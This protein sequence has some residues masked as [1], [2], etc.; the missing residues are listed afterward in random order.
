M[1]DNE[2]LHTILLSSQHIYHIFI[3]S[4]ITKLVIFYSH[5]STDVQVRFSVL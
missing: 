4:R 1:N 3:D 5:G 2:P